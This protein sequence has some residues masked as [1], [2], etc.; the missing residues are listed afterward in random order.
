MERRTERIELRTTPS[1]IELLD[2]W[3]RAQ[4]AIPSRSE[5]V[6][7]LVEIGMREGFQHIPPEMQTAPE[8]WQ[9]Q[10]CR[11]LFQPTLAG[12]D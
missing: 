4:R 12:V 7:R 5:A 10:E 6:R 3:R 8:V 11:L 1:F 2:E 9:D